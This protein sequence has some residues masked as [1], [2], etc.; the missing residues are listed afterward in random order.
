MKGMPFCSSRSKEVGIGSRAPELC[1]C[2]SARWISSKRV[3]GR[4]G[5]CRDS[6][7]CHFDCRGEESHRFVDQVD[8][9]N[10]SNRPVGRRSILY[11][12]P[13]VRS[14]I[15]QG[16][17]LASVPIGAICFAQ[18]GQKSLCGPHVELVKTEGVES[19]AVLWNPATLRCRKTAPR[20]RPFA[21]V[22]CGSRA[23]AGT[24][25]HRAR[26][27]STVRGASHDGSRPR[28]FRHVV[29]LRSQK[30]VELTL[31]AKFLDRSARAAFP[32]WSGRPPFLP[33][34]GAPGIARNGL[35]GP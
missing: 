26:R 3:P 33:D 18:S 29:P 16:W 25:S 27:S 15:R 21:R 14:M 2:F 17:P 23:G 8:C 13:M 31:I 7:P 35:R 19:P 4:N 6:L 20:F 10:R 28:T 12:I 11:E 34:T 1:P 5:G 24:G 22:F 30:T 32:F 9:G